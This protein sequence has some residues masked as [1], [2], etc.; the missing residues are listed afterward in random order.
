MKKLFFLT[1]FCTAFIKAYPQ[2]F[3]VTL[4]GYPL[5]TTGWNYGGD[6]IVVDSTIQLTSALTDQDGYIYFDSDVNLTAC[7]QFS[8]KFDY[9]IV[10]SAGTGIADGIA[11]WYIATPPSGFVLGGGLG[12]P[13]P[14]TGMIFTLDTWDND[15]DG[16]NPES[17]LFGYSTPHTYLESDRAPWMD[18]PILGHLAFMDDGTW[19][20]CE[21]DYSAGNVNVYYDYAALPALTGYY[22]I[23]IPGGYFGFSSSTGAAISTQ[24]V[25]NM[26]ITVIGCFQAGN[27]GPICQGDTLKLTD[28]SLTDTAGATYFWYG[29]GGYTSSLRQPVIYPATLADSGVYHVVKTVGAISDTATTDVTIKR[30]PV[31]TALSNGPVCSGTTLLLFANPDS[32]GETFSWTGPN[33]FISA[34]QSPTINVVPVK[35]GGLYKV[36]TTWNGCID[37]GIVF[38]PVDSTPAL[39]TASSNTPVCSGPLDT[40]KLT[41]ADATTGVTYSWSGPSLFFSTQQNP[42]IPGVATTATGTYSVV[43]TLT[44][45]DG[46]SCHDTGTTNVIID[47]TPVLPVLGS[48]SPVCSGNPLLLTAT[49]S[50]GSSYNWAG[51]DLFTSVVQNPTINPAPTAASG[52]YSVSAT[53]YY[54]GILAGCTS[55]TA[56][57]VVEV[58]STP[59][60]PV[61]TTNSPGPPGTSVCEGDTLTLL[62]SSAT[63]G[64]LY[65]WLGPDAFTSTAANNTILHATPAATGSYTVTATLG[66]CSSEAII[67]VLITP[68]PPLTVTNNGPICTGVQDTMLLQAASAPGATY[69]WTG[70]YTFFSSNENPYRTPVIMEYAGIY[71][72][73]AFLGGCASATVNDTVIV[74][75]T[76]EPPIVPWLTYCQYYTAPPLQAM[77]DSILWY[78]TD[79]PGGTGSLTAPVPPTS[80]TGTAWYYASQTLMG[81]T[82]YLDS[83]KVIVN[84]KPEVTVN[85]D[86][87]ACPHDTL[88]LT[89]VDADPIAYYHWTPFIY[90]T[91]SSSASI[92]VK[93]ET[94]VTYT[95]VATNQYDCTDTAYVTVNV[96]AGAVLN[97]GDSVTLYPGQSYQLDPLTNCSSFSWFP[98]SGLSNANISNPVASPGLSTIYTVLGETS[99]GCFASASI[100]I[101]VDNESVLALPNAFT[102]GNGPNNQF[103]IIKSGDATLNYFRIFD[104][105]GVKVF[106]TT[107]INEGW[108]GTYNGT[109]QP[110][111]VYVY[112]VSAVTSVGTEFVK[113]GNVTLL[114]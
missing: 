13:T 103:K 114:R 112:Q 21:L 94:D 11:F 88:T 20:H 9:K 101:Y 86:T 7:S 95:V 19:H 90:I 60:T 77:G 96:L 30:L 14:A 15:G 87:A 47:A 50:A 69:S 39:P 51:P 32:V 79:V 59:V 102:P 104:R 44:T 52:T 17:Q 97:L 26:T 72:V 53:I 4:S 65:S 35:D 45:P 41:S 16:L 25:K 55:D 10:P 68:S 31:V 33:G 76:P 27:N 40:L 93:P 58:D 6:A 84:P 54:I 91:D 92:T 62:S 99:W 82:S 34:T 5:V 22:L 48:N 67:T 61:A 98:P 36:I 8:V 29:P 100:S 64:V 12:I 73:T 66:G 49:S 110:F 57:L 113:S 23:T 42:I 78:P 2:F 71:K 85:N 106:E 1:L 63:G 56:T 28:T 24:S 81:C 3:S 105:W 89:A 83:I 108:D 111:G 46:L 18:A 107:D 75:L 109:P 43:A 80:N 70:P 74:R 37:S 38:A